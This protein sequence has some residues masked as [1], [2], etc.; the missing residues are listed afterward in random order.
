MTT[1]ISNKEYKVTFNGSKTYFVEDNNGTCYKYF[2]TEKA[3]VKF[4]T[5]LSYQAGL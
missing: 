4:F 1:V 2:S 3:A 5:K